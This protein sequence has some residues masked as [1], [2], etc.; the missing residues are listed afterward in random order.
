M[1]V[2]S[3]VNLLPLLTN[4]KLATD[5]IQNVTS[6]LDVMDSHEEAIHDHGK[7]DISLFITR[8]YKYQIIFSAFD[9]HHHQKLHTNLSVSVHSRLTGTVA[10][11]DVSDVSEPVLKVKNISCN[12]LLNFDETVEL[13]SL[14]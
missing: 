8:N 7:I 3:K 4:L 13:F 6:K 14:S 11:T 1:S 10:H 5:A 12:C 2:L 9:C